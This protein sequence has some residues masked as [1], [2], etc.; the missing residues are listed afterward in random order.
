[1][2]DDV[3]DLDGAEGDPQPPQSRE[4]V[5]VLGHTTTLPGSAYLARAGTPRTAPTRTS[6]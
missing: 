1:M 6:R 3:D 2:A 4:L 5:I